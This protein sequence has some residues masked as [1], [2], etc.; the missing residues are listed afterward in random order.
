MSK[1]K[2]ETIKIKNPAIWDVMKTEDFVENDMTK[3]SRASKL[4]E[5]S[6]QLYGEGIDVDEEIILETIVKVD[7]HAPLYFK[8]IQKGNGI[9]PDVIL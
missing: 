7:V 6:E 2:L 1:I 8:S 5:R 3:E 9:T 4:T